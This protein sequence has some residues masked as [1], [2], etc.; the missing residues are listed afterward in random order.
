MAFH[1]IPRRVKYFLIY[2]GKFSIQERESSSST[3]VKSIQNMTVISIK[4][5]RWH[6]R[7][8]KFQKKTPSANAVGVSAV[9]E[10]LAAPIHIDN[11][12]E[13]RLIMLSEAAEILRTWRVSWSFNNDA[14]SAST[15]WN[16]MRHEISTLIDEI[17]FLIT[18]YTKHLKIKWCSKRMS[19]L[20]NLS[21]VPGIFLY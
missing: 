4:I 13:F 2:N 9:P 8:G 20:N 7:R 5:P 14:F 10:H 15:R 19:T 6:E 11:L 16:V 12:N 1:D 3:A 18:D 21:R 17:L